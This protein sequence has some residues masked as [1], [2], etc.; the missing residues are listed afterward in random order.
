VKFLQFIFKE[1]L[2]FLFACPALLWQI[3][4]LY[5]PLLM[6]FFYSITVYS[7][8]TN[9]I[10]F[11]F[12][13]YYQILDLTYLKI[14][15]NSVILAFSTAL[16]CLII[17]YPVAYFLALKV[18]KKYRTFLLVSLIL[19]SWT[20]LIVQIYAWFF[21]L[22]KNVFFSQLLYKI[23]LISEQTHLL[24]NYFSI[25]VGTV[26]CWIPFMILPIYAVLDRMDKSLLEASSDLGASRFETFRRI[27]FPL[28]FPGVL[29]GYLLVFIPVFG[30]FAIPVLLGG[31]KKIFWGNVI[32]EKFLLLRDWKAGSAFAT[33][34]VL[35]GAL[36]ILFIFFIY[37]IIKLINKRSLQAVIQNK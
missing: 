36:V 24:N 23:G 16:I 30:E 37:R 32:V 19:P 17:A 11:T 8:V 12:S 2:P 14:I 15:L 3:L 33:M 20:N 5:L 25:M 6:L 1:E 7:H 22:G 28:S 13:Y 18:S 34:G 31:G 29:A 9:F 27:V 4:F 21:L 35:L 10:Y 26:Y